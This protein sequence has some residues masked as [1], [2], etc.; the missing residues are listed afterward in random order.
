ML[1]GRK[2]REGSAAELDA[3]IR[4][5]FALDL[6]GRGDEIGGTLYVDYSDESVTQASLIPT[7]DTSETR[8]SPRLTVPSEP[9]VGGQV[10]EGRDFQ[11]APCRFSYWPLKFCSRF[12]VLRNMT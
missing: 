2:C 8:S 12:A 4:D 1:N 7:L 6:L 9:H 10:T 11:S 5:I 3:E